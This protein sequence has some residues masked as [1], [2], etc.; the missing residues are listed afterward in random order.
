M[1]QK[2]ASGSIGLLLL[3]VPAASFALVTCEDNIAGCTAAQT[4]VSVQAQIDALLKQIT[5]LQAQI[6]ALRGQ[7]TTST[8]ST[9][10]CLDLKNA[11]IIGSTDATTNGEVSKLQR[12]LGT[13]T[14]SV[15]DPGEHS[16][17]PPEELQPVT[18]Y[19]GTKTAARVM[20]WQKAHGMDFVT[21]K[22]GVGPMTRTKM[23]CTNQAPLI[24]SFVG[25]TTLG[26]N[27]PGT[28]TAQVSNPGNDRM[29]YVVRWGDE[30]SPGDVAHPLNWPGLGFA[31]E[32]F[33]TTFTHAYRQAGTYTIR[34][35]VV[36]SADVNHVAE[37]IMTVQIGQTVAQ[38]S[39]Y[40]SKPVITSITPSSGPVGTMIE[41]KG[42]NF[43]G[44]EGDKELWFTNSQGERGFLNGQMD[45][46]TRASN[47]VMRVTLSQTLCKINSYSGLD[48]PVLG[49]APGPYTVYSHSYGGNSNTVNFTVTER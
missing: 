33:G 13:Y 39:T 6:T 28:W 11:L 23:K 44:F 5:Q 25:P 46:A 41:I 2:L 18:G 49:L 26:V 14:L 47:T 12:F 45:A 4:T 32:Y 8:A 42:C 1:F 40:D 3:V 30:P 37:K 35:S 27:E 21:L 38:C 34:L 36:D 10:L 43:L 24:S 29:R 15:M 22:S 7:S 9:S 48:C 16:G 19:Y 17:I 20:Q 31:T